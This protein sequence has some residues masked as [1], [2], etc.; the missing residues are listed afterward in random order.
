MKKSILIACSLLF[1][2]VAALA[3]A[4]DVR[5]K[6]ETTDTARINN[7]LIEAASSVESNRPEARVAYIAK[8]FLGTP[9]IASTLEGAP[10]MLTINMDEVDCTTFIDNVAALAFT[11]GE[12]RT[13][14]R[15]FIYNL[16]RMRYAGGE[17]NGYASRLHYISAWI[18]DNS[19]RGNLR[20]V[21]P[22]FPESEYGIKSLD[23]ISTH[24]DLYPALTDS[25]EYEGI[26]NLEHGYRNHRFPYIRSSRTANKS[27]IEKLHEGDIIAITTKTSGLDVQHMGIITFIDGVPHLLHASSAAK[28]VIIDPLPLSEYLRRN[29]NAT[30]IRII[31]LTE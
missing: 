5:F 19:H 2:G 14:W 20:D 30:G 18:L 23:F 13:S 8:K 16:R 7:I 28:K 12:N 3:S 4:P 9:Y 11:L 31:R 6:N 15:D 17:I 1:T 22:N 29:R 27:V 26:R 24:R 25:A 10:E 21:T